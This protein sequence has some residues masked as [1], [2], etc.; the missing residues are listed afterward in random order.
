[1]F[2]FHIHQGSRERDK[3][4]RD[5]AE[6]SM[7]PTLERLGECAEQMSPAELRGYVR[8]HAMPFVWNEAIQLVGR[9]LPKADM[10]AL[11]VAALEQATHLVVRQLKA[12]PVVA[13]PT[14]H[15]R[16]RIAA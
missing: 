8:A 10:S 11:I 7:V 3:L 1:M 9:E 5:I 15:I 12:H 16:L 14:P 4:A 2:N 13:M 6:R